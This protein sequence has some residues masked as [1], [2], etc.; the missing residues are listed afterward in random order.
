MRVVVATGKG[1]VELAYTW[2]PTFIGMN[3]PLKTEMEKALQKKVLGRPL[4]ERVLDEIHDLV[5][6]WLCEKFPHIEGFR[7]YL[8]ALKF[9]SVKNPMQEPA[10]LAPATT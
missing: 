4:D 10:A 3:T 5:V 6:D 9:V 2:L 7:D 8:D 1:V